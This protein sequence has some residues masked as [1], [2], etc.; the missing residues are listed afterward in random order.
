MMV[1]AAA[2]RPSKP[3]SKSPIIIAYIVCILYVPWM[4]I[5]LVKL[6]FSAVDISWRGSM[7]SRLAAD[8][9]AVFVLHDLDLL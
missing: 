2:I 9:S 8:A 7:A 5:K 3:L 1:K 4:E 6:S